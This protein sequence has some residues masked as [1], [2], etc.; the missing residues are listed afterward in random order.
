MGYK[1]DIFGIFAYEFELLPKNLDLS[2][3]TQK[4]LREYKVYSD[5]D[6]ETVISIY[7]DP[8]NSKKNNS[9]QGKITNALLPILS[10]DM[11]KHPG[12]SGS[13]KASQNCRFTSTYKMLN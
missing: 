3:D 4:K 5:E 13:E 8:N 6:I 11:S 2:Y 1:K 9:L 12:C 10:Y 7:L